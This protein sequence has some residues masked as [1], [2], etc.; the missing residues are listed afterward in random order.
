MTTATHP[1]ALRWRVAQA[2]LVRYAGAARDFNDIHYDPAAA[3]QAGFP[4][5]IAHGMLTLSRLVAAVVESHGLAAVHSISCRFTGPAVV[6]SDLVFETAQRGDRLDC[7]V[8]DAHGRPVLSATVGVGE[9]TRLEAVAGELVADRALLIERGPA[10]RFAETVGAGS[11]HLFTARAAASAGYAAVPVFPTYPFALPGW[12][13]FP[14]LPGNE[15]ASAP[16]AVRDSREWARTDGAVIHAG[17]RFDIAQPLYV[18]ETVRARSYVISRVTKQAASR[19]LRFT[20]VATVFTNQHDVHALTSTTSL[21]V[22]EPN[23]REE[24]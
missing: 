14:D 4:G 15:E 11:P 23:P 10:V 7:Q 20:D 22:Q 5:P 13:W 24:Q 6:G 17:Q 21:V 1:P 2:D 8:A 16:D 12:G 19:A 9:P 3:R 18:G